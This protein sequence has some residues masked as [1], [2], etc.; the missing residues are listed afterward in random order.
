MSYFERD[1]VPYRDPRPPVVTDEEAQQLRDQW[2]P[3]VQETWQPHLWRD[4]ESGELRHREE[5]FDTTKVSLWMDYPMYVIPPAIAEPLTE[6]LAEQVDGPMFRSSPDWE[7]SVLHGARRFMQRFLWA[8]RFGNFVDDSRGRADANFNHLGEPTGLLASGSDRYPRVG[9]PAPIL[10]RKIDHKEGEVRRI[11]DTAEDYG[12]LIFTEGRIE[13]QQREGILGWT[14]PFTHKETNFFARAIIRAKNHLVDVNWYDLP[15]ERLSLTFRYPQLT[16]DG[17][18]MFG[19]AV[20]GL[21]HLVPEGTDYAD[22]YNY[23]ERVADWEYPRDVWRDTD[24]D[25]D[26]RQ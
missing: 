26:K 10:E 21:E 12:A 19:E 6:Q 3:S 2:R 23:Y 8:N 1:T 13:R 11:I 22:L 18:A 20:A 17:E 25:R 4:T 5:D 24:E 16:P 14:V 15:R 7:K 9:V